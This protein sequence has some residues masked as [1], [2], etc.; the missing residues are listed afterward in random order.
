MLVRVAL[1]WALFMQGQIQ[2]TCFEFAFIKD[3]LQTAEEPWMIGTLEN[4][5]Q[6]YSSSG[7][8]KP[9]LAKTVVLQ[10]LNLLKL[11]NEQ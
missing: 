4:L 5:E 10:F 6:I 3:T 8:D 7:A 1:L 2:T 11:L 9:K